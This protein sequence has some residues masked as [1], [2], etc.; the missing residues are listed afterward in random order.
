[1]VEWNACSNW[2]DRQGMEWT[3]RNFNKNSSKSEFGKD[4]RKTCVFHNLIRNC[5]INF[6]LKT[7]YILLHLNNILINS[8][9]QLSWIFK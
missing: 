2:A 8:L 1:M 9:F 4:E 3:I 6:L 5:H 7:Q